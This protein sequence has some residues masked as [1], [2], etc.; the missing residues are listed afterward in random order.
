ME[1]SPVGGVKKSKPQAQLQPEVVPYTA[2][3]AK[4]GPK[5]VEPEI[6]TFKEFQEKHVKIKPKGEVAQRRVTEDY[7]DITENTLD[8][9]ETY[10]V[11]ATGTFNG[12]FTNTG[13]NKHAFDDDG[14]DYDNEVI[15]EEEYT[16]G[17]NHGNSVVNQLDKSDKFNQTQHFEN[18]PKKNQ[19][20]IEENKNIDRIAMF[21]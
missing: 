7:I 3:A 17:P 16:Q 19:F 4:R 14:F 1:K 12:R 15:E 13:E 8:P 2:M 6:P 10:N 18:F 21:K 11:S 9:R 20:S 5:A